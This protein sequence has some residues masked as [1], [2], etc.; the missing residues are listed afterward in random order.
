VTGGEPLH[1]HRQDVADATIR[2]ASSVV[3]DLAHP[4]GG[5]LTSFILDRL[6]QQ[7]LG[8]SRGDARDPLQLLDEVSVLM[9]E[10]NGALAQLR[11]AQGDCLLARK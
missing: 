2:V 11:L 10:Q 5:L 6:D 1:H 9:L 4:P 8:S 3:L 7:L